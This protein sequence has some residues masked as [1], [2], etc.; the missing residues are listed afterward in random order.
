MTIH[1]GLAELKT[2]DS[3]IRT[4]VSSATYC[5]ANKKSNKKVNG[6]DISLVPGK[7]QS[8]YDTAVALIKRRNDIKAAIV[9]SNAQTVVTIGTET[10]TVAQAIERKN[11][12]NYDQTL[13]SYMKSNY[14][15]ILG[16]VN[17]EN[18]DLPKKFETYLQA[19]G[20]KE[21]MKAEEVEEHRK[22]WMAGN[23]WDFIDPLKLE[24]RIKDL[25]TKISTFLMEVDAVLSESNAINFIEIGD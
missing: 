21:N 12:I 18:E 8:D 9:R 1:R 5:V 3:R 19:F 6:L 14:N 2:L 24:A 15:S 20:G 7:I 10:M 4:A 16:R 23:E 11:S 17:K 25:E 13:L 22:L